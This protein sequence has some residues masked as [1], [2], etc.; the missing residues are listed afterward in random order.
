M[1]LNITS[2]GTFRFSLILSASFLLTRTFRFA[3]YM[4]CHFPGGFVDNLKIQGDTIDTRY[5]EMIGLR[6]GTAT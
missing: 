6:M 5:R 1:P 2:G 4:K 3:D